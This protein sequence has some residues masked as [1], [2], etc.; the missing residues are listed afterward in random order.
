MKTGPIDPNTTQ[1]LCEVRALKL[2][3]DYII[4]CYSVLN[5]IQNNQKK[6]L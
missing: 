5:I 2:S 4:V 6:C 3:K 1:G